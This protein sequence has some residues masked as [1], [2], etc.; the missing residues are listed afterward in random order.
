MVLMSIFSTI[1]SQI[2]AIASQNLLSQKS[3][4]KFS[5]LLVFNLFLR[6]YGDPTRSLPQSITKFKL[7]INVQPPV[8]SL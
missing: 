6:V 7:K 8:A 3:F 2:L 4:S 1:S 5:K